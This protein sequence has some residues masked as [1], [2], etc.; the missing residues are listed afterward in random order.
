MFVWPRLERR[1]GY[2]FGSIKSSVIEV[3]PKKYADMSER[4]YFCHVHSNLCIN[5]K[6]VAND[7]KN[8]DKDK[9]EEK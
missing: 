2:D 7:K 6:E 5:T 3:S 9:D 4:E 8:N 1:R